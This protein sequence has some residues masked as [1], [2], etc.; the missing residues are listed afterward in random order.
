MSLGY[1]SADGWIRH[2]DGQVE[3]ALRAALR[4]KEEEEE[5]RLRREEEEKRSVLPELP[6]RRRIKRAV[7][8]ICFDCHRFLITSILT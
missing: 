6:V 4:K 2:F 3:A 7:R 1:V 5:E 8:I